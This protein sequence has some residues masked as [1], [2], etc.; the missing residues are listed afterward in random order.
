MS[1]NSHKGWK[2]KLFLAI[3][4][5]SLPH[6]QEAL[7]HI[8]AEAVTGLSENNKSPLELAQ[9]KGNSE[10]ITL[11]STAQLTTLAAKTGDQV[12]D[13]RRGV[14]EAMGKRT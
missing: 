9:E 14:T 3:H 13:G 7:K 4:M 8:P 5:N 10:I 12:S 2:D 6:V 11:L 1:D